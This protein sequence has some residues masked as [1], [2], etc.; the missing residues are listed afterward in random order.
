METSLVKL[1]VGYQKQG[2]QIRLM[3][4]YHNIKCVNF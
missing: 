1:A 2:K 3:V 4:V